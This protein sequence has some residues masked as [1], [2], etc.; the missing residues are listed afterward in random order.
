M[1]IAASDKYHSGIRQ[2]LVGLLTPDIVDLTELSRAR[3]VTILHVSWQLSAAVGTVL[4]VSC[5]TVYSSSQTE[6]TAA[7]TGAARCTRV[8]S[9]ELCNFLRSNCACY[10]CAMHRVSANGAEGPHVIWRHARMQLQ[11]LTASFCYVCFVTSFP[12]K[13]YGRP[14]RQKALFV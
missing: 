6:C 4:E 10:S 5:L 1:S 12:S 7:F 9:L 13:S 11:L 14:R 8:Q 3:L 2:K